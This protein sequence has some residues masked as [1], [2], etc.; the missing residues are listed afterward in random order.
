MDAY[1]VEIATGRQRIISRFLIQLQLQHNRQ[2]EGN[3]RI[4]EA[5]NGDISNQEIE[6]SGKIRC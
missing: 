1:D 3:I 6:A 4:K 2:E 5:P